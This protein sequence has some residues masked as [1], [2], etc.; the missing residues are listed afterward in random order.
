[1]TVGHRILKIA[2]T[3]FFADYGC[4]VRI[5]EE[6]RVLQRLGQEVVVCTYH[7]GRDPE[8]VDVRRA[9]RANP[10]ARG[11]PRYIEVGSN[12][13]KPYYDC[14]LALKA[15]QVALQIRPTVIHAHLHEGALIGYPLSRLLGV[16]LVFDYQGS[17]TSEMVDHGFLRRESPFFNPLHGVEGFINRASSRVITSSQNASDVLLRDFG[18]PPER[19]TTLPDSVDTTVFRPRWEQPEAYAVRQRLGIPEGRCLVVYLGL[20]APYQGTGLLLEAA[21]Q[22]VA[23]QVPVHFLIMG[24]PGEE[25]Y[26]EQAAALGLAGHTTFTGRLAYED[27]PRYLAAGDIAASPKISETEG[28]GK[29]LNYMAAGLPTVAFDT[30]VAREIL[31]KLGMYAQ[32][33]NETDLAQCLRTLVEDPDLRKAR[34]RELRDRAVS[35][36]SWDTAGRSLVRIYD[37]LTGL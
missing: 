6:T 1:M 35:C 16:P 34:G 10:L 20:L 36:F 30:P 8:G 4:H 28:N 24:F 33:G 17:L 21:A 26:R 27:A 22:L 19:V 37:E 3:S 9:P 15:T 2:P 29:L 31:G 11:E 12:F 5:Y 13:R 18:Y 7:T 32:V 23:E 25:A 14:L